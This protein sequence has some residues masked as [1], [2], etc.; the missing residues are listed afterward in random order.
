MARILRFPIRYRTEPCR[1]FTGKTKPDYPCT[2]APP[3]AYLSS[4]A[5]HP[6]DNPADAGDL[7]YE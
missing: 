2:W 7:S 3:P 1:I 4:K 5:N 6:S